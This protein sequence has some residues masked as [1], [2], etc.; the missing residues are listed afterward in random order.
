LK[1]VLLINPH[2]T[3]TEVL[4]PPLG[5][6]YI[7]SY[8][9]GLLPDC[10]FKI[11]DFEAM[12]A[13]LESQIRAVIAEEPDVIGLTA[14]TANYHGAIEL[15]EGVK[16][17]RPDL[18]I[19]MGGVHV[20]AIRG[21]SSPHIDSAVLGE[22]E[23]AFSELLGMIREG[24]PLPKTHSASLLRDI[25]L[26]P[27]W[28]LIDFSLYKWFAPFR[29]S[30]QAVVY[31]SRGCPFDCVFCSNAV[32]RYRLPR[33]RYRNPESIIRELRLLKEKYSVEEVYVFDDEINTNPKWLMRVCEELEKE[34]LR[35]WWKC[36]MRASS[37]LVRE[38]LLVK[39]KRAG[40]W[41]AAWG[42]ESGDDDVLKGIK[43]KVTTG[44]IRQSLSIA[45]EA[46]LVG[47][48]LF[49]IGNIWRG[50]EGRPEG[51]TWAQVM[52]TIQFAKELRDRGLLEYVQF[53]IA[54]PYPGSE[55]WDIVNELGLAEGD[56]ADWKRWGMDTHS[57]TFRHP[58]L[59][60]DQMRTL[61]LKA[62][63]EFVMSPTLILRHVRRIRKPSD[64]LAFC[65]SLQVALRILI[66][67]HARKRRESG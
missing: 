67:G 46:G 52:G 23:V 48:G 13:P 30:R 17:I 5:L 34:D 50:P 25:D 35:I 62:W 37:T 39:M 66:T 33:V 11:L 60:G 44:E 29:S 61:H 57:V 21:V 36:Q 16:Q 19:I 40:C 47:Q 63:K 7:A 28:D 65:R 49:M 26:I 41:Q 38:D 27:A 14:L 54:T 64:L 55:M 22:G 20:T 9:R 43:K 42:L 2:G 31:W 32:W 59:T 12:K 1:K 45:K 6:A 18:H 3:P 53:N 56:M 15:A 10:T 4:C 51:E 58:R 8:C 24:R